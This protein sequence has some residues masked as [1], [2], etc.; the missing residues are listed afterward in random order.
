MSK[1]VRLAV[2][3][4]HHVSSGVPFS[5]ELQLREQGRNPSGEPMR[6]VLGE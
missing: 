1:A 6:T 2:N 5:S 4:R 3:R